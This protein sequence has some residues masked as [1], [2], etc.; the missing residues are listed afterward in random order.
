MFNHFGLMDVFYGLWKRKKYIILLAVAAIVVAFVQVTTNNAM[1]YKN[2]K[3]NQE[4]TKHYRQ[5][6]SLFVE[7]T[8]KSDMLDA[9]SQSQN[10]R[11][12]YAKAFQSD[13][14]SQYLIEQL[15]EEDLSKILVADKDLISKIGSAA[16]P[17]KNIKS[18]NQSVS[19][20]GPS[21]TSSIDI[22]FTSTDAEA[23]TNIMDI[24]IR[25]ANEEL[26]TKIIPSKVVEIGRTTIEDK[27]AEQEIRPFSR[28]AYVMSM[29]KTSLLY[30]IGV[31]MIYI[32]VLFFIMLFRPTINRRS[33]LDDYDTGCIWEL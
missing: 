20:S 2:Q 22:S 16:S 30:I 6:F 1:A 3:K 27:T 11:N 18:I 8:E 17:D 29:I 28:G 31:E 15:G 13:I 23:G 12:I 9:F 4:L 10:I 7:A 14:F 26:A 19:I 33:D 21:D 25:Y 24:F 32:I 5:S